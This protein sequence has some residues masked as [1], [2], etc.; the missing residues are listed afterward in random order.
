[1]SR[2]LLVRHGQ[3]S[4]LEQDY[5][6]LSPLGEV[7]ARL[8]GEYWAQRNLRFDRVCAG[9]R[10]RQRDTAGIV[11]DAYQRAAVPFP[12]FFVMPEFDEHD[13]EYILKRSL[14]GLLES[15]Q[16]VRGLYRS[17][18]NSSALADRSKNFQRLLEFVATRW[19]NAGLVI[20][21]VESWPEFCARVNR[22]I[23]QFISQCGHGVTA[24]V[25]CSGGP[26]A[27]A[28]ERALH[29]TPPNTFR[30]M[31]MSRNASY[32]EFLFS[33][34]RFTLSAFNAFPHLDDP[35]LL[36]YR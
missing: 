27:V 35:S 13:G 11:A 29:L 8:L 25:F 9:P 26:I 20:P 18:Q 12:E 21:G 2:L 22:G 17:F 34:D 4:F 5:D 7:Q 14:P 3:A 28:V 1:M 30:V 6:K 15:S 24:A 32:S 36:T 33:D 10:A 31:W 23:S 16:E 19:M